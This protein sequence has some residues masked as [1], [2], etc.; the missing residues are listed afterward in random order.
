MK[1][2]TGG[3]MQESHS[4][5]PIP[6][7][8]ADFDIVR[9]P[10]AIAAAAGTNSILGGIV[11]EADRR[12]IQIDVPV[13]FT[14]QSGGRVETAVFEEVADALCDAAGTRAP[15]AIVLALHGGMLTTDLDDPEAE[16]MS[17]LRAVVGPSIPIAAAFDLHAHVTLDTLANC[18]FLT[19]FRTNPHS[20]QGETGRRAL[21]AAAGM[22]AGKFAPDCAIARLPLLTLGADRT[23]RPGA[24]AEI[25]ARIKHWLGQPG[26]A[27][28]TLFNAQQFLDVENLGQ[29]V[30]VYGEADAA[31]AACADIADA[32]WAER[33]RFAASYPALY[34]V[35]VEARTASRPMVIGDQGDRV[36]AGG[37]GDST[38][39]ASAILDAFPDLSA[40]VPI[41]D[42]QAVATCMAAGAG[43]E[44][45]LTIGARYSRA[46]G[47]LA[48]TGKILGCAEQVPVVLAGPYEEGRKTTIG[49][50]AVLRAGSVTFALTTQPN[51]FIDPNYFEAMG[52]RLAEMD[53]IVTRSGYHFS[54]NYADIGQCVTAD[55]PGLTSYQFQSMDLERARPLYPLDELTYT[56][57]VML[58]RWVDAAGSALL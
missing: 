36:A 58:R 34:D 28:I 10:A 50:Y 45:H 38:V 41:A 55:T 44:V 37:P 54:L 27:D 26:I 21:V 22:A 32:V 43:Q 24:L 9:G 12:G 57:S 51:A 48:I 29:T 49:P 46:G 7:R 8:R 40:C 4:F 20:D 13:M 6:A 1:I 14:A 56:P 25:H 42:H 53:V 16:L 18:Q 52:I 19:G 35:L 47:P 39:I 15:D 5:N 31:E 3:I 11:D 30:L 17:R 33:S 2:L 23:D